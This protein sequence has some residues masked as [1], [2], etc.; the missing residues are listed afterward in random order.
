MS[1]EETKIK[2]E[3]INEEQTVETQDTKKEKKSCKKDKKAELES[4]IEDLKSKIAKEKDDYIRLMAEFDNFR[5]RSAEE[6]IKLIETASEDMILGILPVLDDFERAL[7]VLNESSDS[8][9]SKEGMLLMYNKLISLLKSKG[10]TQIATENE[11]FNT[12]LHEAVAQ[13]PVEEQDKKGKIFD[14]VLTGYMLG[15]KV[16]RFAKVVVSI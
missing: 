9:A 11:E 7:K 8:D 14:V 6:R 16:I 12:D 13:F 2:N 10:V 5:R 1:K 4:E 3:E 15:T